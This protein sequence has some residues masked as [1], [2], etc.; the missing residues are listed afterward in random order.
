MKAKAKEVRV[1]DEY[2]FDGKCDEELSWE[3]VV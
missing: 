3:D 2:S 1:K